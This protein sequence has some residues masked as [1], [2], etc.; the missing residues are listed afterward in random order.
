MKK[1]VMVNGSRWMVAWLVVGWLILVPQ[2][3]G[4]LQATPPNILFILGDDIGRELLPCYGGQSDYRTPRLE[5]L[6]AAGMRFNHCYATPMCSPSR[7]ELLTGRYSFRNYL[8]WGRLDPTQKTFAQILRD[9]G[10]ATAIAGK[11]QFRGWDQS[12]LAIEQAGF[13]EHHAYVNEEESPRFL[14]PSGNQFWGGQYVH[15]GELSSFSGYGEDVFAGAIEAFIR[16]NRDR[17]FLAYYNLGLLHRPF[18]PTPEDDYAPPPGEPPPSQWTGQRGQ[19]EAF[20]QMIAYADRVVGRLLDTLHELGLEENTVVIFTADNGTDNVRE[21][22]QLRSKFLGQEVRGGKYF[23]TE[24]GVNVP[25]LVRWPKKIP[26]GSVTE[27]LVDFTDLFPTLV[28]LAEVALP[29]DY[30]LDGRSLKPCFLG[31]PAAEKPIIYSWGNFEQNSKKYKEPAMYA[32]E[33]LHVVRNRRWKFYSDGRLY[34]LSQDFL[35]QQPIPLGKDGEADQAR[36]LLKQGLE[37][38]RASTPRLW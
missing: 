11:W 7:V 28:D 34:D 16:R 8:Q 35:E 6:A 10:Y 14:S 31:E 38:L 1:M 27:A 29:V 25:L 18:Q 22:S 37:K 4:V 21:A 3:A 24:L 32:D 5:A 20:P 26:A 13:E 36:R 19:L 9:A 30:W 17:P 23:P 2:W 15:Q 33:L 12:P